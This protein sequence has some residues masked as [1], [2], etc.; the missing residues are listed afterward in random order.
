[1]TVQRIVERPDDAFDIGDGTQLADLAGTDDLC[2]EAHVTVLGALGLQEVHPVRGS[3]DSET[4]HVVQAAGLIADG[5]EF[6]VKLDGVT[7]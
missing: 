7:L 2:L 6:L 3:G 4:A 1:M 5:F